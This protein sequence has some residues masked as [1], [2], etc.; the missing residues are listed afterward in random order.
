M[1]QRESTTIGKC[2]NTEVETS[3]AKLKHN[4]F[5][6]ASDH[7]VCDFYNADIV[8]YV[9][10]TKRLCDVDNLALSQCEHTMNTQCEHTIVTTMQLH[11]YVD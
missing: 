10:N 11:N 3:N 9:L 8:D 4:H 7:F 1:Q 5:T 2:R 6:L